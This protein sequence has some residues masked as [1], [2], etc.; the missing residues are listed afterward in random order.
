M[1][2]YLSKVLNI[3]NYVFYQKLYGTKKWIKQWGAGLKRCG[4][5][6]RVSWLNYLSPGYKRDTILHQMKKTFIIRLYKLLGN[7]SIISLLRGSNI[8]TY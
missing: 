5:S 3:Q 1:K 6:C 8:K 4:S 7:R 2:K